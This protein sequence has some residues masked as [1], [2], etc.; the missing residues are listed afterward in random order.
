MV[1]WMPCFSQ[2][3]L[4]GTCSK[5]CS[6]RIFAF[7]S[8]LYRLRCF[9]FILL[10]LGRGKVAYFKSLKRTFQV[11]QNMGTIGRDLGSL[12]AALTNPQAS[13]N[14]PVHATVLAAPLRRSPIYRL[15]EQRCWDLSCPRRHRAP[16]IL[17]S[18]SPNLLVPAP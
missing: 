13:P 3:S 14:Y 18:P 10:F 12:L 7:S 15:E 16:Q 1:G 4:I 11:K 8:G 5:R 6:R 2:I 17:L 9:L